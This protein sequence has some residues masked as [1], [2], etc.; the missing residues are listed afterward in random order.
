M[1]ADAIQ[2]GGPA[3]AQAAADVWLALVDDGQYAKVWPTTAEH[4]PTSGLAGAVDNESATRRAPLGKMLSRKLLS[5]NFSKSLPGA[6]AGNY[7]GRQLRH[8]LRAQKDAQETVT[9]ALD[10]DG[11]W[12][13]SGYYVK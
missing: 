10:P 1:P 4:V 8:L 5:A 2:T 3:A 11:Q 7:V 9:A 13:V 12:K 6:P